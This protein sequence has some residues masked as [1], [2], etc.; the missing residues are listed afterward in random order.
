MSPVTRELTANLWPRPTEDPADPLR[1][2]RSWKL[3]AFLSVA[4]VNFTANVSGAGPASLVEFFIKEFRKTPDEVIR[5]LLAV[6]NDLHRH[7]FP[8]MLSSFTC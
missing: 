7:L 3:L 5:G 6:C 8:V 2:S 1:W 4:L